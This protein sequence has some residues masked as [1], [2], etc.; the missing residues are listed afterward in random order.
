M[1]SNSR[2]KLVYLN[3]VMTLLTQIVSVLLGFGI[4]KIFINTL[5]VTYLG[6]NSVFSNILQM[7]NLADLGIG[8]AITSFLY[9]PIADKDNEKITALMYMYKK[10]YHVLGLVVLGL[11]IAISIFI[12][13]II[14]DVNTNYSYLRILF[15]INLVGT[16][17]TYYLAYKRTLLIAAQKSYFTTLV[18]MVVYLV[19]SILQ[20]VLLYKYPSYTLYLSISIAKNIISNVIISIKCTK[21]YKY[22]NDPVNKQIVEEYKKPIIK[23]VKDVF[24][25][26]LGSYVFYSTDNIIISMFKGAILTGYLSNYT[27]VTTQVS[28][29]IG[30][31][32]VSIQ[33][34]FGNYINTE[35][36]L[37]NQ[38]IM[39]KNYLCANYLIGNFCMVCTMFLIQPFIGLFFGEEYILK[40]S[41]AMWLS[42]N[43]ML[44]ILMQLP[45]QLF[46]I[47]K[48]YRYDK[49]IVTVSA[50]LNIIISVTLVNIMGIDG[51]LIGTFVTSLI[52]LY[53]RLAIVSKKIY[54][55]NFLEYFVKILGYFSISIIS[56]VFTRICIGWIE[57]NSVI[58]FV[59][60]MIIVV[61]SAIIIPAL[62]LSFTREFRYLIG[63][64]IPV[65]I[66]NIFFKIDDS[67]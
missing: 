45:S 17:S 25:S 50:I 22:I 33:A 27:L 1:E 7:L 6:Y 3:T 40:F 37:K 55:T 20:V 57:A 13:V 29:V 67:K 14:T 30:Q 15:F 8:V 18:D 59:V 39:A 62:L 11:G 47:Y 31:V 49:V 23:Y 51:V 2:K 58:T 10:V 41:T 43:L 44:T 61:I 60:R 65:K 38:E 9:K 42:I 34:I 21:E 48:L 26:R 28:N 36:S 19:T 64:F 53:S 32:L 66:R 35:K 52:Y 63:K 46:M 16:V 54:K 24:V 5:G 12:P 4:R 56:V